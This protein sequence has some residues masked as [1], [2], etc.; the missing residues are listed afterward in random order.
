M[1]SPV[2]RIKERLPI[3]EVVSQYVKLEKAGK[4]FKARCPFHRERTASFFVSP[5][6][7]TFYCFGCG[8]KGDIFTLVE[9]LEGVDFVGALRILGER[10]GIPASELS[11]TR[12]EGKREEKDR[13]YSL[14]EDA[15]A[16]F[17]K[18]L[19][20]RPDIIL[21]LEGRGLSKESI[22]AWRL[23]YSKP[24]WRHLS[25]ILL[26]RYGENDL[27]ASGLSIRPEGKTGCYDRFR[28]RIVFPIADPAGRIIAFSG[29][30][31]EKT[32]GAQDEKDPAK[33]VN[34]PETVLFKKSLVLHGLD[35]AKQSIRT[36]DFS[37][38]V[39]GQMD[40]LMSHQSGFPNTTA[41]SGTAL[42]EQHLKALGFLSKRLVL[43]LDSDE[44]GVRSTLRSARLALMA[45]F[46]V[47]VATFPEDKDPA[48]V[49]KE[50][51][52]HYRAAI[53]ASR[54]VI[55]FALA[56]VRGKTKDVRAF[57]RAAQEEVLP[58]I[59]AIP[60]A[61]ERSHFIEVAARMLEVPREAVEEDMRGMLRGEVKEKEEAE[62]GPPSG[63]PSFTKRERALGM[64]L[65][66]GRDDLRT[67]LADI[68][69]P[70]LEESLAPHRERFLF[71]LEAEGGDRV[72]EPLIRFLKREN[73]EKRMQAIR[74]ELGEIKDP[75]R[76]TELMGQLQKLARER[77]ALREG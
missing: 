40:L 15:T 46:D 33:Y 12:T 63:A 55:E 27:V 44:A 65:A 11:L 74:R 45:G 6:R 20:A 21:Y 38:L 72:I 10:A 23:G 77:E 13:F 73:L 68:L 52:D 2:D 35:R 16:V 39:E 5:E 67:H 26:P 24:E 50:G 59:L 75:T 49:A 37:V 51:K 43:A 29:R 17:E 64:L 28:G 4:S 71:E 34:S 41:L 8:E 58:L 53:R 36:N 25:D 66:L 69:D 30:F 22:T 70:L 19:A 47:K 56:Y 7:G 32:E 18:N 57:R 62:G 54:P 76:E 48:D 61:I 14:L 1:D 3:A 9:R 60:S 31:F 42:T